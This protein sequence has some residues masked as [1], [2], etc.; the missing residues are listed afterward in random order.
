MRDFFNLSSFPLYVTLFDV[1]E[2]AI[3]NK[4]LFPSLFTKVESFCIESNASVI[5][6]GEPKHFNQRQLEFEY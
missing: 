2:G 6:A 5:S 3:F 4:Y 1:N